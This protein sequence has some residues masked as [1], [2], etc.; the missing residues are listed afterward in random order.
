VTVHGEQPG[1]PHANRLV[2]EPLTRAGAVLVGDGRPLLDVRDLSVSFA[3]REGSVQAVD[4]VSFQLCS[5]EVLAIV[6][7]SGSGKSVCAMSLMGL[8]RGPNASI[9]GRALFEG[10][11]LIGASEAQLRHI[12]GAQLAMVFQDPQSSLNPVYRVGDQIAEQIR[13]HEPFVSKAQALTR[14]GD[15]ME[16]VGIARARE[17]VR[18]YPHELSGGMRQ[19]VMI[20]MALSLGA[21]VLLADE[22]TTALDV[23]V[24]AQI[25]TR[26]KELREQEDLSIVLVTH[27]FGVVADIADRI[28]V[29]RAGRIVEQGTAA[30]V[31]GQPKH[32]YTRGL[33]DALR[34]FP[35]S[36]PSSRPSTSHSAVSAGS[37]ANAC[38][39]RTRGATLL[40]GEQGG[41]SVKGSPTRALGRAPAGVEEEVACARVP[42]A[43]AREK[44]PVE[45]T[46][47]SSSANA[48]PTRTRGATLLEVEDLRVDYAGRGRGSRGV[49]ALDGVTL[50][51]QEGETLAI[52]GESGCGKTTLLRSIARL[53]EPTDGAIRLDGQDLARISRR[54]LAFARCDLGMVFQDPQASLNPRRRVGKTLE[55]ALRAHGL[56]R[57][58]AQLGVGRLL[59]RVGLQPA[60]AARFPHELSGGERQRVGIARALAGALK[61]TGS[62]RLVLLDEPV[63]S[64]DASIRRG[65][66]ELL[67]ELQTE[68]GCSYVL[69]SHDF[70]TVEAVADRIAVMH[71][72]KVVEQGEARDLLER[73]QHPYTQELLAACPRLPGGVG[74]DR[75]ADTETS[76]QDPPPGL[77]PQPQDADPLPTE[78]SPKRSPRSFSA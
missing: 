40:E 77:T 49:A 50:T 56:D 14:A 74:S 5:G 19:R 36:R 63:S 47:D 45:G 76:Q 61:G 46:G 23:T 3:T 18:A 9:S 7:E 38:P 39:T 20:A 17:R 43:G 32:P 70:T 60:K 11:D 22:P 65:V 26:L 35:R 25:L 33:L 51:V 58:Q 66:I 1:R 59:D 31:L 15:L 6:G 64:L 62:P 37:S 72:G 13:A 42:P 29:M 68:L 75:W 53:I 71:G 78:R 48:C 21:K 4:G 69:V 12:R 57:A 16:R 44:A 27:D 10:R 67:I 28:A 55:R 54:E 73:P 34:P 30:E 24:Q 41:V 52:V 8:T 2:H